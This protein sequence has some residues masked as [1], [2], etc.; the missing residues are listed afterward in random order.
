MEWRTVARQC[1][2]RED[3]FAYF[4]HALATPPTTTV[5]EVKHRRLRTGRAWEEFCREVLKL[6]GYEEV[7]LLE[8]CPDA[9][10]TEVHLKRRDMGIDILARKSDEVAWTAVQC[11]FRA[12]GCITWSQVATFAALCARSGPFARHV[13]MT[14][15][16]HVKRE[17]RRLPTDVTMGKGTFYSLKTH[18]WL[19]LAGID[20]RGRTCGSSEGDDSSS[21]ANF[22]RT[23]ELFLRR[24][25]AQTRELCEGD[26]D[27]SGQLI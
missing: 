15:A 16:T 22:V 14:N 23:R 18:E 21:S 2:H 3:S 8:E 26:A 7:Y 4:E 27:A 24:V 6:R 13:V 19:H 10:L 11:K 12:R 9:L 17:G 25:E 1:A 20:A 5:L